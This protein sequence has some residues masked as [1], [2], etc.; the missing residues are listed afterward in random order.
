MIEY[1]EPRGKQILECHWSDQNEKKIP[2]L[3]SIY[4]QFSGSIKMIK[5]VNADASE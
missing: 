3:L 4:G 1:T 2:I 5:S